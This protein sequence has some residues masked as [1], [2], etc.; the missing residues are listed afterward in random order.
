[1][2]VYDHQDRYGSR[3]II[4]LVTGNRPTMTY[5]VEYPVRHFVLLPAVAPVHAIRPDIGPSDDSSKSLY[6]LGQLYYHLNGT[7]MHFHCRQRSVPHSGPQPAK[8][9][10][11]IPLLTP[12]MRAGGRNLWPRGHRRPAGDWLLQDDQSRA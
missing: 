3:E 10:K 7:H 2:T 9:Q 1:M 5:I 12:L 4:P 6:R 8:Q 11:R